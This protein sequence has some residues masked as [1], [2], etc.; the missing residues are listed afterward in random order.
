MGPISP[1]SAP[2][3]IGASRSPRSGASTRP[4]S[5]RP[6]PASSSASTG[7]G[8]DGGSSS[9]PGSGCAGLAGRARV[10]PPPATHLGA[11]RS[12]AHPAH[13]PPPPRHLPR[14]LRLRD[15]LRLDGPGRVP[16]LDPRGRPRRVAHRRG[17]RRVRPRRLPH[18]GAAARRGGEGPRGEVLALP[19]PPL[20]LRVRRGDLLGAAD[21]RLREPRL[22][23]P[24]QPA[25]GDDPPQPQ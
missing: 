14:D 7:S 19:R 10:S 18:G 17:L 6:S 9:P 25:E 11:P 23:P 24:L 1:P 15:R 8:S 13:P 4:G 22:V 12:L 5:P 21:L 2:S 20:P 16:V 3:T